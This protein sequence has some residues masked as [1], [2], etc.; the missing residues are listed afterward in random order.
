MS[1]AHFRAVTG[2]RYSY[3]LA[4]CRPDQQSKEDETYQQGIF[5]KHLFEGLDGKA[6]RNKDKRITIRE[7]FE[8]LEPKVRNDSNNFQ[9]PVISGKYDE[10]TVVAIVR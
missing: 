3:F 6:D 7:L 1:A 8:Y 10:N 2:F 5:S 4:S 9:R